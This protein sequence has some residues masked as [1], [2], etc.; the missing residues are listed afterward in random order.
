MGIQGTLIHPTAI[1]SQQ[2]R[3]RLPDFFSVGAYSVVDDYSYFSAR[4]ELSDYVHLASNCTIAGG[5]RFLFRMGRFSSVSAGCRIW[6]S[7]NDY[8]RNLVALI[9][10]DLNEALEFE[11]IE[12]DVIFGDYTG[13]GANSVVMPGNVVPEG[14]VIGALSFVPAGFTFEPWSVYAGTPIRKIASRDRDRVLRQSEILKK[15]YESFAK[16]ESETRG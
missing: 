16:A 11:N 3:F 14:T 2:N 15:H 6:C 4:I 13:L 5:R 8:K 9:P 7:S 1:V 12:G 10:H